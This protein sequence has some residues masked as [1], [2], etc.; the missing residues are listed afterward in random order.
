MLF[1]LD[2]IFFVFSC[3]H[4]WSLDDFIKN[5]VNIHQLLSNYHLSTISDILY[6]M[7]FILCTIKSCYFV[8]KKKIL[9]HICLC[10][11]VPHVT[12]LTFIIH[13]LLLS[14]FF[15]IRTMTGRAS[16]KNN[17]TVAYCSQ[18]HWNDIAKG[19]DEFYMSLKL[20]TKFV[21]ISERNSLV[22]KRLL[23]Y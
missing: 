9:L 16:V 19:S 7:H 10:T 12:V 4:I 3:E 5:H 1:W 17:I 21:C 2:F 6:L 11:A 14:T 13:V 23:R 8:I 18:N 22:K 20:Q 15:I